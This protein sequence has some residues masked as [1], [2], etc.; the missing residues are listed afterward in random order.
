MGL[1]DYKKYKFENQLKESEIISFLLNKVEEL[2]KELL[3]VKKMIPAEHEDNKKI[4]NY[5]NLSPEE[6]KAIKD[7]AERS[8]KPADFIKQFT[9]DLEEFDPHA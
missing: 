3:E 1:A 9:G 2:E 8:V 4:S 5:D 6:K 7:I